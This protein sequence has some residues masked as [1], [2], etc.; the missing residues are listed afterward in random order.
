MFISNLLV[1]TVIVVSQLAFPDLV[2][3]VRELLNPNRCFKSVCKQSAYKL[4]RVLRI[5][6]S[7]RSLVAAS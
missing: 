6:L 7:L 1:V 2:V 3:Q 5:D 4:P